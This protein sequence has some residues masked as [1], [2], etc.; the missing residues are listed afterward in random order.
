[1]DNFIQKILPVIVIFFLGY[2]LKS[3]KLFT[4]ENGSTLLK[5]SFYVT[6]PALTFISIAQTE[7]VSTYFFLPFLSIIVVGIT[8]LLAYL[9]GKKLNL[10]RKTFGTFLVGSM[11]MNTGFTLPFV[12]AAYGEK[13]LAIYTFYDLGNSLL[14]FTFIYYQAIKFGGNESSKIPIRKIFLLPPIWGLLVGVIF[15]ILKIS[16]YPTVEA[17]FKAIGTPTI[18]LMMFSL[19]IYFNPHLKN[20]PKILFVLTIRIIVG[21]FLGLMIVNIFNFSGLIKTLV[22]LFSAAPVGYNTLIFSNLEKLDEE[23]AAS[24]VSISLLLGIIYIPLILFYL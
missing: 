1:M 3:I 20:L 7:L 22:I 23:F 19:G 14:I 4:K 10:S 13:G 5:I 2:I 18:F 21:F 8:F 6:L 24:I 15:N 11:I 9:M 12:V 16:I 17:T